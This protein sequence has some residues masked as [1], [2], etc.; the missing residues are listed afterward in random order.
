MARALRIEYED[1]VYHVTARGNERNRIFFTKNDYEKFLNYIREAKKKY[2]ILVHSYVL[3]SNHYHLIIETPNANLSKA[4]Q[5]INGS[6]TT[7]VNIKKKRSGH[8]FQGRYKAIIVDVDNYLLELSRYIHLN[9]VRAKMVEKP[10][11]YQYSSYR[12]Y[13]NGKQE[14]T[15]TKELIMGMITTHKKES[16]KRYKA[17]VESAIN[18]ESDSPL[19][20]TYGG[21]IL[22]KTGFIKETLKRLKKEH[23]QEEEIANRRELRTIYGVEEIIDMV[24]NHFHIKKDEITENNK[25]EQRKITLYLIKKHTGATNKAIGEVFGGI[26]YSAVSKQYQRFT[27]EL[28]GDRKLRRKVDWIERGMSNVKV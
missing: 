28:E 13:I 26:S 25:P 12:A 27:N 24:S 20:E 2:G 4:M 23:L 18:T 8:L 17:F 10:E 15:L 5:Y 9:P 6:Y 21:I 16:P 19:K 7:Y 3:M 22:G 14:Q 1:A 11:E